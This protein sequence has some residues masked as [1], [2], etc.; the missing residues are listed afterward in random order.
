ME[1]KINIEKLR[2][3]VYK[4]SYSELPL[5]SFFNDIEKNDNPK[6][7]KELAYK[8]LELIVDKIY[9]LIEENEEYK[10]K[11]TPIKT[12]GVE[13][14][15]RAYYGMCD[16]CGSGIRLC[17]HYN[18]EKE[19]WIKECYCPYCGQKLDWSDEDEK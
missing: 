6:Y 3:K 10:N 14:E 15:P 13:T 18:S 16:S 1:N 8:D 7:N 11:E 4:I 2:E 12:T 5:D 19:K 9:N 17:Q